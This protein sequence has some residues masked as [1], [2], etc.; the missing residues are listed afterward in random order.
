MAVVGTRRGQA[1]LDFFGEVM[2]GVRPKSDFMQPLLIL[3]I[4]MELVS[5]I[6]LQY[7]WGK[8]PLMNT[9]VGVETVRKQAAKKA[10][11]A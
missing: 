8:K 2:T 4:T 3:E 6:F 9:E 1:F 7:I 11:E 10:K 5:Q